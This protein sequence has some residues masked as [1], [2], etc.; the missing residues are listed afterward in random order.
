MVAPNGARLTKADHPALPMTAAETAQTAHA[1]ALAGATAIHV[2]VRDASGAHSLD[3][4]RYAETIQQI[5]ALTNINIQVSTE[6]AGI[7]DVTAQR[8]CLSK[9]T[10]CDASV[11]LREIAREP[12][13][14]CDTYA[15]VDARGI[16]VQHILYSAD[17]VTQ[18]LRH[19]DRNEIPQQSRRA[20]FVLGR[21]SDGQVSSP[22]DLDPFLNSLGTDTL[23]WSVCA[24]GANE[25]ACLIAALHQGGN[26]RVGF[27]NNRIAPDGSLFSDNAAAVASLV[28]AAAKA[29]FKPK[30]VTS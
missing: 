8:D 16:D 22:S 6:A 17:E 28:A 26:V 24:F 20:I 10:A 29:G 9:V 3:P 18:L 27:E 4:A 7:F 19:F 23:N 25:Q 13:R 2:H 11:S 5:Q 1:C 15:M 14:L 21:Y 12:D 30:Q